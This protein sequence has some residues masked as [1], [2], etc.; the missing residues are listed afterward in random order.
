MAIVYV[1]KKKLQCPE[2]QGY[3]LKLSAHIDCD[4]LQTDTIFFSDEHICNADAFKEKKITTWPQYCCTSTGKV[5]ILSANI[6]S[7]LFKWACMALVVTNQWLKSALFKL[8]E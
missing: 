6:F 5:L 8:L 1:I 4:R 7:L 2:L 3:L